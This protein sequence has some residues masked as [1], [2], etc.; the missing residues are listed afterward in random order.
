M[1]TLFV[2]DAEGVVEI[3]DHLDAEAAERLADA[4]EVQGW[5][6]DVTAVPSSGVLCNRTSRRLVVQ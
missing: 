3:I 1:F 2:T 5:V 6:V 4:Y